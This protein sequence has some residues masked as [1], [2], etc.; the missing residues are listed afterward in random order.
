[1]KN[2]SSEINVSTNWVLVL[3]DEE[4]E[5]YHLNGRETNIYVGR[6]FMKYLYELDENDFER[7]EAVDTDAHHW[8][9]TG[10]V[11][12]A[13][14]RNVFYG[15][16]ISSKLNFYGEDINPDQLAELNRMKAASLSNNSPVEV[17][18]GDK[19]M[20]EY[21]ISMKCFNEGLIFHTELG[22]LY[23]IRYDSLIGRI[24][25]DDIYP[26]N[27]NIF[28]EWEQELMKGGIH[29]LETN[30][31]DVEKPIW[32]NVTHVGL[33]VTEYMDGLGYKE[34]HHD[35]KVGDEVCFNHFDAHDIESDSHLTIFGGRKTYT[36]PSKEA[37]L[38]KI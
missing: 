6:S 16:E 15:R 2:N 31:A 33:P 7:V 27:G 10:R 34:F 29:L 8:P 1:M 35:L 28:V 12:K 4:H 18:E 17:M 11:I 24:R 9:I 3:P 30:I 20:F 5:K 26:L 32:A 14:S 22:T 21:S 38:K 19:V 37:L 36:L 23:L 13:P 25:N